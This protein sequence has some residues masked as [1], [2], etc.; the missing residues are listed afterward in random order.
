MRFGSSGIR[1]LYG[2]ELVAAA[3]ALGRVLGR[4][5]PEVVV[6]RD[7]RTSSRVM[8]NAF[9]AGALSEGA[10]VRSA[11]LVPT[12]AVAGAVPAGGAGCMVTASHNPEEYNG[13]KVFNP[14]GSSF[15]KSQQ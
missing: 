12:P 14:G 8:E 15:L 4:R 9:S 3:L 10:A 6:G 2:R 1:A 7:T 13:L 11:G 5:Y